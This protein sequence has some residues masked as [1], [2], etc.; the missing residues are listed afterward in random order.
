[1]GK[2]VQRFFTAFAGCWLATTAS[3]ARRNQPYFFANPMLAQADISPLGRAEPATAVRLPATIEQSKPASD[4]APR[5][6]EAHAPTIRQVSALQSE[7]P[8]SAPHRVIVGATSPSKVSAV[9]DL[10][11]LIGVR[12][13]LSPLQQI[14]AWQRG[15][16]KIVPTPEPATGEAWV[17]HA[18]TTSTFVPVIA[19]S[20]AN[21]RLRSGDVVVFDRVVDNESASLVALVIDTDSRGVSEFFYVAGGVIRRGYCDPN[22]PSMPRD[23]ERRI[24]NTY[25]RHNQ[26]QPPSGTHFLAGELIR[27][28]IRN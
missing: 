27:G 1:L 18:E 4:A 21:Q 13:K 19:M 11:T 15:F 6:R 20:Q 17:A 26:N 10:R 28:A 12:T 9:D 14:I 25:V 2:R 16:D 7:L 8:L 5:I 3:C 22:R 24:V 23:S